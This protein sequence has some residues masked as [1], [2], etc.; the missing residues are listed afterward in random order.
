MQTE[1]RIQV[2]VMTHTQAKQAN[3]QSECKYDMKKGKDRNQKKRERDLMTS[4]MLASFIQIAPNLALKITDTEQ[5]LSGFL[6]MKESPPPHWGYMQSPVIMRSVPSVCTVFLP[7]PLLS[8]PWATHELNRADQ[9]PWPTVPPWEE[10]DVGNVSRSLSFSLLL[11]TWNKCA[12]WHINQTLRTETA[13]WADIQHATL[14]TYSR[15]QSH[16]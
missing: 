6:N 9:N 5:Q 2:Y 7:P 4:K 12:K 3:T 10:T 8:W 1:A 11:S 14:Y 15:I 16:T 13:Y